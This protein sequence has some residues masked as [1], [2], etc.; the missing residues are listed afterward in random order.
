MKHIG[1]VLH[2]D[3]TV[4]VMLY[5]PGLMRNV[6]PGTAAASC[7]LLDIVTTLLG[8]GMSL[9]VYWAMTA[10]VHR[11]T[12]ATRASSA[13]Q[14]MRLSARLNILQ[15]QVQGDHPHEG[16]TQTCCWAAAPGLSIVVS[17]SYKHSTVRGNLKCVYVWDEELPGKRWQLQ[18]IDPLPRR[19]QPGHPLFARGKSMKH[20]H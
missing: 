19:R 17:L 3:A 20:S 18:V 2:S 15:L 11:I 10:V 1:A 13:V 7:V 12:V 5:V 6:K 8:Q 9:M 4:A 16:W 14:G